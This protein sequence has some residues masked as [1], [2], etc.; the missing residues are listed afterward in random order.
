MATFTVYVP[1]S[2]TSPAARAERTI[3]VRDGFDWA[4]F[5]FGPLALLHRRLWLAAA[6]WLVV[7]AALV[8]VGRTLH[9]LPATEVALFLLLAAL[10]GLETA[11]L[12]QRSLDRRGFVAADL[13]SRRSREEAERAYFDAEAHQKTSPSPAPAPSGATIRGLDIGGDVIGSFPHSADRG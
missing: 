5:L 6:A 13:L 8:F 4:A 1:R 10:T 3:F 2:T 9:L 11:A 7:A 12:R